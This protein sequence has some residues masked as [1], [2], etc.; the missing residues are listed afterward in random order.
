LSEVELGKT[1]ELTYQLQVGDVMNKNV[2]T[3]APSTPMKEL[4]H[5]LRDNRISGA[6]VVEDESLKGI[7][8]I[9]DFIKWLTDGGPSCQ[10]SERMTEKV[11][12]LYEDEP[13]IQAVTKLERLGFGRLPVIARNTGKL[14]GIITKGNIIAGLLKKLDVGYRQQ[15]QREVTANSC[16]FEDIVADKKTLTLEYQIAGGDFKSA[17]SSA[18]GLKSLLLHLGNTPKT[19][20]RVAIAIYEAEMNL[21]FFTDG[22]K[23]NAKIEPGL[24]RLEVKDDG[25]GI[26]DIEKAMKPGFSTAPDWVRELGF[27]AGMGLCNIKTCADKMNLT[28][29]SDKGTRLEIEI[30]LQNKYESVRACAEAS[31]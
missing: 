23:I 31:T 24:I 11:I 13:V 30:A 7:I 10:I 12:T 14:T 28:S 29:D 16:V 25:P 17:G 9:E 18:S 27:G 2:I 8:S 6:P 26:E 22:G 15:E 20:R 1:Q 3:V 21:I 19:A 4:R 5:V